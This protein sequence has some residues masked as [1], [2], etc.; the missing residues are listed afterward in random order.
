MTDAAVLALANRAAGRLL[1]P[2][3]AEDVASETWLKLQ[4]YPCDEEHRLQRWVQVLARSL[5]LDVVRSRAVRCR[6]VLPDVADLTP[7]VEHRLAVQQEVARLADLC[8]PLEWS[9]LVLGA[10]GYSDEEIAIAL[11]L[12]YGAVQLRRYRVR[13]RLSATIQE[14]RS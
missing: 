2:Q 8:Q 10:T 1:N 4:R 14:C 5:A 13:K 6:D 12:T 7:T 9:L 11:G 3:D